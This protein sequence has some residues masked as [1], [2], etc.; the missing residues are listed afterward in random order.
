M[1]SFAAQRLPNEATCTQFPKFVLVLAIETLKL[2][3]TSTLYITLA[4]A[5]QGS[6]SSDDTIEIL[7]TSMDL[8]PR[9]S[10]PIDDTKRLETRGVTFPLCRKVI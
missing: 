5:S 7:Q 8:V 1:T 3:E 4:S 9:G 6:G 10:R 2:D